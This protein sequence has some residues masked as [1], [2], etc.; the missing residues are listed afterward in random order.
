MRKYVLHD[1]IHLSIRVPS[2]LDETTCDAIRR[3][4][5]SR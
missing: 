2:D 4:L 1:E 3:I 5:E